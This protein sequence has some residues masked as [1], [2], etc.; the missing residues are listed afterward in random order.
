MSGLMLK[1]IL[2]PVDFS[3]RSE[4]ALQYAVPFARQFGARVTLLHVDEINYPE[5]ACFGVV[6]TAQLQSDVE[7]Q[8][9]KKLNI[10]GREKASPEWLTE[11]I[12]RCGNA[13]HRIV[14]AAEEMETDLIIIS[15]HGY[16]GMKHVLLGGT[17]ENIVRHAPCP[18][19]VVRLE[20]HDF[21]TP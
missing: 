18:V 17:A 20:E 16:T 12:F 9:L 13:A 11:P 1:K 5:I 19:M 14:E 21:T 15:T 7:K 8:A 3:S 4:K 6:D 2:V 10:L